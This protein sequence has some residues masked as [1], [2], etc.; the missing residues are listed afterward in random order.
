MTK[1]PTCALTLFL[2]SLHYFSTFAYRQPDDT[3]PNFIFFHPDTIR[4]TALGTYGNP[5][6]ETPNY[7]RLASQSILFDQAHSQHSQCSP[8]RCAMITGRYMHI[9]GHRTQTHLVQSW[10]D[11]VFSF[12]KM[13][14]YTNLMLGKNDMLSQD[15]FN[16]SFTFWTNDIGVEM[17]TNAYNYGEAGYYSFASKDD[18]PSPGNNSA[19]NG[20]LKAVLLVNDFLLSDPPEPFMIYLPGVGAHPP[21]GAPSDYYNK[22]N[23]TDIC[24]R[25]PPKRRNAGDMLPPYLGPDGIV[26]YRNITQFNELF[27]C[28]LSAIYLGRVAYTDYVLGKLLDG[29]NASPFS[30]NTVIIAHSDHGD[31]QGD[32]RAVEKWPGGMEDA[33][34]HV[35]LLISV[36]NGLSNIRIPDP[37]MSIDLFPTILELAQ[38]NYT[39]NYHIQFGV[40]LVPYLING[41]SPNPHQYVFSEGGYTNYNEYEPNDPAQASVYSDPK[42]MYFPRGNEEVDTPTHIDRV[43]MMKNS[44]AKLVY[45]PRGVRELYDLTVDPNEQWNV[46]YNSSY[47]TLQQ[48]MTADLL[49]WLVLTS[50]VTPAL[51]DPRGSPTP[52]TPPFPWPPIPPSKGKDHTEHSKLR[53][54]K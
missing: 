25:S 33:L 47:S 20:D 44:T 13:N 42:N 32:Y 37:V 28:Q 12:L 30:K 14:N 29:I 41:T 50:D 38:V 17:G 8:S 27:F 35:P 52:P 40:S 6:S 36:P 22:Y 19:A 1:F 3:R 49:S 4:A 46:Y 2:V 26:G 21:Y 31:Y 54:R 43:I 9:L 23:A 11:N 7:D 18:S 15:S 5:I 39:F 24:T 34:T 51:E 16:S 53:L 45:R 48:S 10:E